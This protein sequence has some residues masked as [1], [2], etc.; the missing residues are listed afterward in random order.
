M[1]PLTALQ[2][3]LK[4]LEEIETADEPLTV[5]EDVAVQLPEPLTVT[6]YM[7]AARPVLLCVVRPLLHAKV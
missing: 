3:A 4:E 1:E 6:V 7:P 2:L 5:I